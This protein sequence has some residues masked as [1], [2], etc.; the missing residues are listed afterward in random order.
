MDAKAQRVF[1]L[2]G[3]EKQYI[4][5][6]F[7]RYYSWKPK[8]WRD[9]W[10]DIMI[11][12]DN[13]NRNREHFIGAFVCMA[14]KHT[15]DSIPDYN[16]VDGQQRLITITILLCVLRDIAR[17][18][19]LSRQAEEI[20]K[21][22][23]IDEYKAGSER[24]K[25]ISRSRDRETL[26]QLVKGTIPQANDG[27]SRAA[28]YFRKEMNNL[29]SREINHKTTVTRLREIITRQLS[30]VMITL[31]RDDNP[32]GI[33]ETLNERGQPLEQ[34]DLIRNYVFMKLPIKRQDT[35][36]EQKWYP[37]ERMFAK[38]V[39]YRSVSLTNF[40]RNFLMRNGK[41]VARNEI[42]QRFKIEL[43]NRTPDWIITDLDHHAKLY[44]L[45]H[46]PSTVE[47]TNVSQA[48]ERIRALD[49]GTASPLILY[50]LD[51]H[52]KAEISK[53]NLLTCL[54]ALESFAVRRSIC[55]ETTRGYNYLFP[56]AIR[57]MRKGQLVQ[58]LMRF[59]SVYGWPDDN[60]FRKALLGFPLYQREGKKCRLI[61]E[62]LEKALGRKELVDLSNTTIEH[63]MPQTLTDEWTATLGETWSH[64][65]KTYLH[66]LGNL[67]LTGY[68]PELS[69]RPF[70][71]KKRDLSKSNLRL[72][73][74]VANT[75]VWDGNAIRTRGEKLS[76]RV[77]GIWKSHDKFK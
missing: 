42:Y 40:Y 33:F 22:Y 58:S 61:L 59:L 38:N 68:N 7:Q 26:L 21:K 45:I 1:N 70:N 62:E 37:F 53:P 14:G 23:L 18:N 44:L 10:E 20:E 19:N 69:N 4:V 24:Y 34:S 64:V 43:K 74:E 31:D 41:Y 52:S 28:K 6:V 49:I 48:L 27:I 9:L 65:H 71:E 72:N 8:H 76:K 47:D 60:R 3:G 77:V 66:T 25:V 54:G 73:R 55:G 15:P 46:R 75:E 2:L 32:F 67:T 51:K 29:I 12:Y 63:I 36:D 17:E 56:R 30:L 39:Q 16:I 57:R 35:F 5:P 11:L 13:K 50:L